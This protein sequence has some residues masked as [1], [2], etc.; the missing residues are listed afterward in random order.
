MVCHFRH[1]LQLQLYTVLFKQYNI[2]SGHLQMQEHFR[3][4]EYI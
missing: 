4:L 2:C 3:V 1:L